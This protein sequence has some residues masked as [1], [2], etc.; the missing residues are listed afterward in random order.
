[1][2]F[3]KRFKYTIEYVKGLKNVVADTFSRYY[4][5]DRWDEWHP[6]HEYVNTDVCLDPEGE[7]CRGI[8]LPRYEP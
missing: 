6:E 3:L 2:T 7:I 1:M 4:I 8:D 5:S